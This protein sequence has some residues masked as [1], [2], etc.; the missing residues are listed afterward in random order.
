M[1]RRAAKKDGNHHSIADYLQSLGYSVLDLSK[2]GDGVPDMVVG[3]P[4]FAALVEIKRPGTEC[5]RK[6]TT[7]EQR[8]RD[9]WDGPYVLAQSAEE[10]AAE[11]LI[12]RRGWK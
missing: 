3:I 2:A 1:P 9:N 10:A 6:L 8:V 5:A 7:A 11:L 4:G 12:L